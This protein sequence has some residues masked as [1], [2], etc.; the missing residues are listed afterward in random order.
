MKRLLPGFI[1]IAIGLLIGV[2]HQY[3]NKSVVASEEFIPP[4]SVLAN[5]LDPTP[6]PSPD[7]KIEEIKSFL[8]EHHSPMVDNAEDFIIAGETHGVDYKLLVALSGVESSF[9][10]NTPSCARFNAFG[11]RSSNSPC[12]WWRFSS[13]KEAI[14]TVAKGL[15]TLSFYRAWKETNQLEDLG[16]VYVGT[17]SAQWIQKVNWFL[18]EL[19]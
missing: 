7:P 17:E 8:E 10:R 13:F 12:G 2:I 19:K 9:G 1:L 15:N 14:N 11:W 5:Y 4:A 6:V 18:K 16:K 3:Q